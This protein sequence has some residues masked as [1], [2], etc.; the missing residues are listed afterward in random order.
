MIEIIHFNTRYSKVLS[1]LRHLVMEGKCFAE[2][3]C[4]N[5]RYDFY[6]I[7]TV[8]QLGPMKVCIIHSIG[9]IVETQKS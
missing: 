5:S 2:G 6:C 8:V 7:V 4:I 9:T 1:W 3:L